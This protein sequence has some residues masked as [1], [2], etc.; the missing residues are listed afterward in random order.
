MFDI[1]SLYHILI[2]IKSLLYDDIDE[3][4]IGDVCEDKNSKSTY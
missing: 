1:L 3:A 2:S 4:K